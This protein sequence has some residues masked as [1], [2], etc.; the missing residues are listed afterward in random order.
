MKNVMPSGTPACSVKAPVLK[1]SGAVRNSC[2]ACGLRFE[3][4]DDN[5]FGEAMFFGIMIGEGSVLLVL[6]VTTRS[7]ALVRPMAAE[8]HP[9]MLLIPF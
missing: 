5:Y 9:E 7:N 8:Q 6:A 1:W 2:S 3:R 4:T